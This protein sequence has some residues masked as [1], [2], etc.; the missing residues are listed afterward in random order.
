MRARIATN[1]AFADFYLNELMPQQEYPARVVTRVRSFYYARSLKERSLNRTRIDAIADQSALHFQQ[2]GK[3]FFFRSKIVTSHAPIRKCA[4]PAS[5]EMR[6]GA[7]SRDKDRRKSPTM[8]VARGSNKTGDAYF[9]KLVLRDKTRETLTEP[10]K[11]DA[12]DSAR[13]TK[14]RQREGETNVRVFRQQH[15]GRRVAESRESRGQALRRQNGWEGMKR[16]RES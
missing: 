6:H 13:D 15:A 16:R 12:R 1:N 10:G 5:P 14:E 4:I 7:I 2:S 3:S 8:A 9:A 11:R